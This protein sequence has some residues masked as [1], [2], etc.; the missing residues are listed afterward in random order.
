MGNQ[1]YGNAD[2]CWTPTVMIEKIF[3]H[4]WIMME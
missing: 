4:V 1:W 3:S 2:D